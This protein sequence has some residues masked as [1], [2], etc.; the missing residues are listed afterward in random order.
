MDEIKCPECGSEMPSNASSCVNCGYVFKPT[1]TDD[2]TLKEQAQK[3]KKRIDADVKVLNK[4]PRLKYIVEIVPF[5]F[6]FTAGILYIIWSRKNGLEKL[7]QAESLINNIKLLA[8]L[9]VSTFAIGFVLDDVIKHILFQRRVAWFQTQKFDYKTYIAQHNA[10]GM[11]GEEAKTYLTV[12]KE[13]AFEVEKHEEQWAS[14]V[15]V[16]TQVALTIVMGTCFG[17]W[18]VQNVEATILAQSLDLKYKWVFNN[19]SF[20]IAVISFVAMILVGTVADIPQNK[21]R[22]KWYKTLGI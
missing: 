17:V 22:E 21:R 1:A 19:A 13:T 9:F 14:L 6:F 20:I 8:G 4:L 15:I 7:A 3:V 5:I 16:V 10:F 11:E 12:I 18:A 2:E